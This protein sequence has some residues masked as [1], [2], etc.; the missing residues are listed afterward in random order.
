[1]LFVDLCRILIVSHSYAPRSHF[2]F[3]KIHQ[4][5]TEKM[6]ISWPFSSCRKKNGDIIRIH[7][8]LSSSSLYLFTATIFPLIICLRLFQKWYRNE[9]RNHTPSIFP[10]FHHISRPFSVMISK[11]N[12]HND[13]TQMMIRSSKLK[14]KHKLRQ[15]ERI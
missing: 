4:G 15:I 14:S 13:R 10:T 5:K 11:Q 6:K 3:C 8:N 7:S 12:R 1:M 2:F 9:N